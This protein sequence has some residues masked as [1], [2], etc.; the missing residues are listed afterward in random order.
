MNLSQMLP[1]MIPSHPSIITRPR[2]I[3][4]PAS[5]GFDPRVLLSMTAELMDAFV[6]ACAASDG[7]GETTGSVTSALGI[8]A[9][10]AT[11]AT[12]TCGVELDEVAVDGG[13]LLLLL[14]LES[15]LV[16]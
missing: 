11:D 4:E 13:V 14:L 16:A 10:R 5:V 3:H 9:A 15:M 7:A 8:Y 1:Q 6:G 2:A 12:H